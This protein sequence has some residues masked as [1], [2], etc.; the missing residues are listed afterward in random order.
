MREGSVGGYPRL[1]GPRGY[2]VSKR[3][4]CE[5]RIPSRFRCKLHR[6][7]MKSHALALLTLLIG[8]Q[9]APTIGSSR[10]RTRPEP[11]DTA[12][13]AYAFARRS[14]LD[15]RAGASGGD[16]EGWTIPETS[17]EAQVLQDNGDR[18][19]YQAIFSGSKPGFL[20]GPG[21]SPSAG[22]PAGGNWLGSR[23]RTTGKRRSAWPHAPDGPAVQPSRS[24]RLR[25]SSYRQKLFPLVAGEGEG[26]FAV[27]RVDH[28][29]R[30]RPQRHRR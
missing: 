2:G 21:W 17:S 20:P 6:S 18:S 9:P 29:A 25:C 19:L 14:V 7:P 24:M 12:G 4:R 22:R 1:L 28:R 16:A 8:C 10:D 11:T 3:P 27:G 30:L 15:G 5:R 13:S 26:R 23:T